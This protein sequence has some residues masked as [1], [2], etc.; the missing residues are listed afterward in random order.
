M[1]YAAAVTGLFEDVVLG[2]EAVPERQKRLRTR[3]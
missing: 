1:R 2:T 3:A